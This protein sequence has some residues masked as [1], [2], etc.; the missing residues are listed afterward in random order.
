MVLLTG[1]NLN[2]D[3]TADQSDRIVPAAS[4]REGIGLDF[5]HVFPAYSYTVLDFR[6]DPR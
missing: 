5:F 1:G 2:L 4:Q 6:A 3:N